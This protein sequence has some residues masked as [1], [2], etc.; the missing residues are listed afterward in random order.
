VAETAVPAHL[1]P[2]H[3]G[4]EFF[5]SLE[6]MRG[7][8]AMGVVLYHVFWNWHY[9]N[10]TFL[11][12][13][14]FFVDLFFIISGFVISH[15]YI[16][17]L[18]DARHFN[19]FF[20]LRTA[21]LYP[22]H[23]FT[24]L[25]VAGLLLLTHWLIAHRPE[26][27]ILADDKRLK[28]SPRQ[29]LLNLGLLQVLPRSQHFTFNRPSWSISAEFFTYL[30][31]ALV[32]MI[33]A[34]KRAWIG[35]IAAVIVALAG[36]E[37]W[38]RGGIEVVNVR[39]KPWLNP[40]LLRC[41]TGFF[42]GVL[43]QSIWRLIHAR[44]RPLLAGGWKA[45]LAELACVAAVYF[46]LAH[47]FFRREQFLI[48]LVFCITVLLFTLSRGCVTLFLESRPIQALG[49]WS[50]SIY[51][52]HFFIL[53]VFADVLRLVYQ[54]RDASHLMG[55][56]SYDVLTLVFMAVVLLVSSLTYRFIEVPPR[57]WA[58]DWIARRRLAASTHAA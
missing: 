30:V 10:G 47:L 5:T 45:H 48:L 39:V 24:L 36:F 16:T 25:L 58:K 23:L 8:A 28:G 1:N 44:V 3:R 27:A 55:P 7:I 20:V 17:R 37:I 18:G 26:F 32:V 43:V 35:C 14:S 4:T 42:L 22:L 57:N 34:G 46:A 2:D 11:D 41:L 49:R 29:F 19:E 6:G 21:R 13:T 12:H 40:S 33:A 54:K 52:T 51:L 31:F 9:A 15:I 50:Y 53:V 56:W 38:R